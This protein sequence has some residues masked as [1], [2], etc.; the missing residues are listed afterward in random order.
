VSGGGLPKAEVASWRLAGDYL[1]CRVATVNSPNG[2]QVVPNP[3]D[4]IDALGV[5]VTWT[6]TGSTETWMFTC[7]TAGHWTSSRV[8]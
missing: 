1:G 2:I 7:L 4:Q 5:G 8:S 3:A 6:S